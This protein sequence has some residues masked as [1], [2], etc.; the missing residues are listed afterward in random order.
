MRGK[1]T[2]E[3]SAKSIKE[4]ILDDLQK[5]LIYTIN[6]SGPRRVMIIQKNILFSVIKVVP[7]P[8]QGLPTY[9]V[10]RKLMK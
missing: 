5:S 10:M 9:A 8:L 4:S 1:K 2:L 3:S 6:R 7:E